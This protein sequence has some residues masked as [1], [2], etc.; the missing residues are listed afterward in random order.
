[1]SAAQPA[2]PEHPAY[3]NVRG[4]AHVIDLTRRRNRGLTT[5]A[6]RRTPTMNTDT[7]PG[8]PPG[9]EPSSLD[10]VVDDMQKWLHACGHTLTDTD[11]AVVVMRTLEMVDHIVLAGAEAHGIITAGQRK[12]LSE[13]L[14]GLKLAAEHAQQP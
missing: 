12:E 5:P 11:T 3:P 8:S 14:A 2:H 4:E 9:R 13:L 10:L 7:P 6:G 1:M